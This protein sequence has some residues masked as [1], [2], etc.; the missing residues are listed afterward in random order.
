M[1]AQFW[2]ANAKNILVKCVVATWILKTEKGW[3]EIEISTK[4]VVN[5]REEGGGG[6]GAS[7]YPLL[8]CPLLMKS[9]MAARQT[10]AVAYN[11]NLHA[12]PC[13]TGYKGLDLAI[14][15]LSFHVYF[16]TTPPPLPRKTLGY[17]C[18]TKSHSRW[19]VYLPWQSLLKPLKMNHSNVIR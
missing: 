5:S 16:S 3:G 13:I 6:G 10:V 14:G 4:G 15:E 1:Q 9:N 2:R 12:N 18:L 7:L 17:F 19:F 11:A 8:P